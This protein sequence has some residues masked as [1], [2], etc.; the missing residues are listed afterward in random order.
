VREL[1]NAIERAV[2]LARNNSIQVSDLQPRHSPLDEM[3]VHI[4]VGT[5]LEESERQLTLKTFAFTAGDH[6]K[7]ARILGLKEKDL[8]AR[9][10]AYMEEPVAAGT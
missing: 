1:K 6:K 3:E 5:S 2:I 9:L 7:T 4:P 10:L 8:R